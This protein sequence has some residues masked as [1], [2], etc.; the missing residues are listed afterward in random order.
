MYTET[1]DSPLFLA[2][3]KIVNRVDPIRL[4][5]MGCPRDEYDSE[6]ADIL[7]ILPD[8]ISSRELAEMIY[9]V[10][11]KW[12]GVKTAGLYENYEQI[13]DMIWDGDIREID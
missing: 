7:K 2:V 8:A 13:A 3:T 6:V 9:L 5:G 4:I 10:F 11:I 12:F 1:D